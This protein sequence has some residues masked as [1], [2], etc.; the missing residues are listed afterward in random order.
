[1]IKSNFRNDV[2]LLRLL[3]IIVVVF[4]HAYGMTYAN[5]LAP[6]VSNIYKSKYEAL[7]LV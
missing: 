6:E 5:H 7:T 2:A 1:M 3:C 4:F